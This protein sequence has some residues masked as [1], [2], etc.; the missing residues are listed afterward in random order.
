MFGQYVYTY[1]YSVTPYPAR[2]YSIQANHV[3]HLSMIQ[4][5]LHPPTVYATFIQV[6]TNPRKT[7]PTDQNM[8]GITR[9]GLETAVYITAYI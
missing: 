6:L 4:I 8:I 2:V 7:K 3:T 9:D 1:W 5:C